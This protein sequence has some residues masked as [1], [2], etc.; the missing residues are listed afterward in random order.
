M[1]TE[2]GA[3]GGPGGGPSWGQ[4]GGEAGCID[5]GVTTVMT[6]RPSDQGM[7]GQEEERRGKTRGERFLKLG[8]GHPTGPS[9]I[10][11]SPV[12]AF[13]KA[14]TPPPSQALIV[15]PS[16]WGNQGRWG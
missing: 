5:L 3:G 7:L 6:V 10:L 12:V 4:L 13:P 8:A 15:G 16:H 2:E 11:G 9:V 14:P 1:W